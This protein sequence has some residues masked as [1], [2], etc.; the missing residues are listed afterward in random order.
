M[1]NNLYLTLYFINE[2]LRALDTHDGSH[3]E[4]QGEVH[5]LKGVVF[6][7]LTEIKEKDELH[8]HS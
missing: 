4:L 5:L 3:E 1:M 7:L 2:S 8:G 6:D